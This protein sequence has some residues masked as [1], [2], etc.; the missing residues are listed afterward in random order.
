MFYFFKY[1]ID[2]LKFKQDIFKTIKI[3]GYQ[4]TEHMHCINFVTFI[5]PTFLY[6]R[7]LIAHKRAYKYN[8]C[9]NKYKFIEIKYL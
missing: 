6:L 3:C 4:K 7:F 1:F 8:I 2:I 5:N 9:K